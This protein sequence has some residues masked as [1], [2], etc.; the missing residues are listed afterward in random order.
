MHSVSRARNCKSNALLDARTAPSGL[1]LTDATG[2]E[3]P[4][5]WNRAS[6]LLGECGSDFVFALRA[7]EVASTAVWRYTSRT[8]RASDGFTLASTAISELRLAVCAICYEM[9]GKAGNA[10]WNADHP[11]HV[12]TLSSILDY[13]VSDLVIW[14]ALAFLCVTQLRTT[15]G[16]TVARGF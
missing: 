8:A 5:R 6:Y 16:L 1:N 13:V 3:W 9:R 4:T 12:S 2:I 15:S 14:I 7:S 11:R 10:I